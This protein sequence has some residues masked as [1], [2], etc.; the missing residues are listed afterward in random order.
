MNCS[1]A[2]CRCDD[3][4]VERDGRVYC[5]EYCADETLASGPRRGC[6]CGHPDC[7]AI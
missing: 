4:T 1:H 7:A 6:R 3:A 5:S 2:D